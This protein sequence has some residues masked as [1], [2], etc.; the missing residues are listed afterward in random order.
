MEQLETKPGKNLSAQEKMV[1]GSIW[2]TAGNIISRLLGAVYVIPWYAWLGSDARQANSLFSMGYNV[3]ALFLM[4]STA[5]IPSAIAKQIAH[6]NSLN[7]YKVS[8]RLF[9][10][11]LII[12]G[13]IGLVSSV[14]MYFASPA[15]ANYNQDLIPVM[16]SLSIAVLI[17][18]VMSAIRGFFQGNHDMV[19][20]AVSQIIEQF[21]RVFYMLL[22]TYII[23]QVSKGNYVDAVV[24]STF[25]AFVGMLAAMAVLGWFLLRYRKTFKEQLAHSNDTLEV[26]AWG[27]FGNIVRDAIPFILV[28]SSITFLKLFDQYTFFALMER[29]TSYTQGQ[30]Y[31]LFSLFSANPDKLTMVVIG[32]ATSISATSLPLISSAYAVKNR[33]EL[34]KLMED[35]LGLFHFIMLPATFGIIALAFPLNTLFYEPSALGSSIL[36]EAA[37]VGILIALYMFSSSTLQGLGKHEAAIKYLL[38]GFLLKAMMQIPAVY[39]FESFGP[40]IST[41]LAVLIASLLNLKEIYRVAPYDIKGCLKRACQI[42]IASLIMFIISLLTRFGLSFFLSP[43]RKSQS[44]VIIMAVALVGGLVYAYFVLKWHIAENS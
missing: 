23:M 25:A 22:M 30:L 43:A 39:F 19:P 5:G 34:S 37:I 16:R 11:S 42:L 40:L 1:K 3:Y 24:Q 29:F 31:E 8:K 2:L 10:Q 15:L 9:R 14:V 32:I 18:P 12:M 33:L 38:F 4:I 27:I 13:V 17:F 41:G 44:F 6:Y 36:I 28:G 21:A 35:S 26:S 7:E 20:T